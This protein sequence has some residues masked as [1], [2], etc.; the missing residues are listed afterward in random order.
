MR[1]SQSTVSEVILLVYNQT[2]ST[3]PLQRQTI[4][5]EWTYL[6][7]KDLVLAHTSVAF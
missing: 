4:I 7:K 2:H 1:T 3:T 5:T 6:E